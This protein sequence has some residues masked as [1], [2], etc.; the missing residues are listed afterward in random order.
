MTWFVAFIGG[1][2][3]GIAYFGGLWRT[4][5]QMAQTSQ[6]PARAAAS[7]LVRVALCGLVFYALS[8]EGIGA[9]LFALG[10]FWIAR[11]H[12]IRRWGV[13]VDGG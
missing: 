13:A 3:V 9:A 10:G 2:V 8:R 6:R 5:R 12:L 1:V 11:W 7:R 4:V